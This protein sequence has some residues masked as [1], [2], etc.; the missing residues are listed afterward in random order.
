M[1]SPYRDSKIDNH[2]FLRYFSENVDLDELIWHRDKKDREISVLE[3]NDW[4]LQMDNCL[5]IKLEKSKNYYIP[6]EVY[7]RLIAGKENL[8]LKI[9]ELGDKNVYSE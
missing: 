6:A 5:P 9:Q 3:G 2:S 8:V 1:V 4:Q 7:H